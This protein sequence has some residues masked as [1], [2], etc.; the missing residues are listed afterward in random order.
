MQENPV[1]HIAVIMDGNGR[2]AQ[3]RGL[4]R[5]GGHKVG[6]EVLRKI[7]EWATQTEIEHLTC[8]AFSTENWKRP[9]IEVTFLM[10]LFSS[11]LE[12][13][14]KNLKKNGVRL[15]IIGDKA[16]LSSKLQKLIVKAEAETAD[17][18]NLQLN[19]A[20]NYGSQ[21]D[22]TGAVRLIAQ[23][24]LEG[25]MKPD[26]IQVDT[27]TNQLSTAGIPAPDLLIRPGGDFRISNYLLWEL[28]YTEFFFYEKLWPDFTVE[29]M[30]QILSDFKNRERRFGGLVDSGGTNA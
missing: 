9:K 6:A 10:T 20:V 14:V 8:Y 1:T 11:Y 2:W 22:I 15:K 28:A 13:E 3:K 30:E 21:Q 16:G 29:D 7:I 4:P 17:G 23:A 19:L 12:K 25:K 18:Q 24:V 27:I 26:E 5:T